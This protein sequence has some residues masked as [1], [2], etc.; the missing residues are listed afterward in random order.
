MLLDMKKMKAQTKDLTKSYTETHDK[1]LKLI[2]RYERELE[3]LYDKVDRM[4]TSSR[5]KSKKKCRPKSKKQVEPTYLPEK[6]VDMRNNKYCIK[7][8]GW[9][10]PTWEHSTAEVI[11]LNPHLVQ[12]YKNYKKL[13]PGKC[14]FECQMKKLLK[15][16]FYQ[17]MPDYMILNPLYDSFCMRLS[18]LQDVNIIKI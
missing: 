6:I 18:G 4:R 9:E 3:T 5:S 13:L 8:K 12:A 2:V 16:H 10:E 1:Q 14:G 15:S 7:W 11:R 17:Q